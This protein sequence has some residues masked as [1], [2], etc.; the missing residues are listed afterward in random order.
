MSAVVPLV[1]VVIP[2]RNRSDLVV[3]AALSALNQTFSKLEVIVVIDGYDLKT[4]SALHELQDQ[5][6]HVLEVPQR[7]G[8]SA[9]RNVGVQAARGEWIAFLDDDDEWLQ[10]KIERQLQIAVNSRAS[11]P[12]IACRLLAKSPKG[13]YLWPRRTLGA[14]EHVSDFVMARRD[15]FQGEGLLQTS[16]L[17]ARKRLLESVPFA[18]EVRRHQEWDWLLRVTSVPG[19]CIEFA[20]EPLLIWHVEENRRSISS[21]ANWQYSFE[22]I[23]QRRHLV[24]RRAYA[25]FLM[26]LVTAL[27]ARGH[28]WSAF[29]PIL[30]EA[31]ASGRPSATDVVVFTGLWLFPEE[32][33]RTLRALR[34]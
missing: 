5:R 10:N 11:E 3:R 24:T 19:V 29:V 32:I 4:S 23:R 16:M 28:D 1:S 22:W 18:T 14:G 13:E 33:R 17:M 7:I 12:V 15:L 34:S 9:A 27:A 25:G 30:R 2:T 26:T 20:P 21:Q 8:G 31:F 6:L